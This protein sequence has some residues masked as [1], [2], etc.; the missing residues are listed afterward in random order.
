[1]AGAYLLLLA[2][3]QTLNS[4]SQITKDSITDVA[5][6]NEFFP[7]SPEH[8]IYS[9]FPP[10]LPAEA[11]GIRLFLLPKRFEGSEVIQ[12]RLILSPE[13]F[14]VEKAR[15]ET[16]EHTLA[17]YRFEA[18]PMDFLIYVDGTNTM[19]DFP[20]RFDQVILISEP[21]GDGDLLWNHGG[22][23]G[24]AFSE[25]RSEIIYWSQIW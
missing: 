5:R 7:T 12:L 20:E 15:L 11:E 2:V 3:R 4:E 10:Q 14:V 9:H 23:S 19:I 13:Q 24:V 17:P 22:L 25:A 6:Y 21:A 8:L 18:A 16:L 1:M